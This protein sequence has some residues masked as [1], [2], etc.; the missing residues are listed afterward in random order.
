M[1][2][3]G[4]EYCLGQDTQIILKKTKMFGDKFHVTDM[5]GNLLLKIGGASGFF[6][7]RR[8]IQD[9]CRNDA[10]LFTIKR[11]VFSLRRT[12]TATRHDFNNPNS[13]PTMLFKVRESN[14]C[15][16]KISLAVDF[17]TA[18]GE[19]GEAQIVTLKASSD[20]RSARIFQGDRLIA[21]MKRKVSLMSVFCDKEKA[22]IRVTAGTDYAFIAALVRILLEV[23]SESMSD[24][25][26]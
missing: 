19:E 22:V 8:R 20:E 18:A 5:D 25:G 9:P 7:S 14:W 13:A 21:E 24:A 11:K 16:C 1:A 6:Q 3:A 4:R 10:I 26:G 2:V 15:S 12:W 23:R 17:G